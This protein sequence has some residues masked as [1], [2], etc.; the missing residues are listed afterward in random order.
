MNKDQVRCRD[1]GRWIS[2]YNITKTFDG[3]NYCEGYDD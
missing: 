3:C 1:C 2:Y